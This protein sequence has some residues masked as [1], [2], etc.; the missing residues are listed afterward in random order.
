METAAELENGNTFTNT[1]FLCPPRQIQA[2]AVLQSHVCV[3]VTAMTPA[4]SMTF[5]IAHGSTETTKCKNV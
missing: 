5:L 3:T 4:I 2:A 1:H